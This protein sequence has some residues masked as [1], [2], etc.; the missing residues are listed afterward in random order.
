LCAAHCGQN[1]P[2][3]RFS[4]SAQGGGR[5]V[6]T[7]FCTV[8]S[9]YNGSTQ[10]TDWSVCVLQEPVYDVPIIPPAVGC[11]GD[12]A[13]GQ[14]VVQV[15]FGNSFEGGGWGT[16]RFAQTEVTNT[17]PG[18]I[19]TGPNASSACPGDSGGPLL[20]KYAD[21]TWRTIGIAST[22]QGECGSPGAINAYAAVRDAIPW[23]EEVTGIDVTPCHDADGRWNPTE[24]CTGF[25]T[26]DQTGFGSW[27]DW[28]AGTPSS[29]PS[30]TCG[31]DF[32]Q[33]P[34]STPPI[35]SITA[36]ANNQEF[37]SDPDAGTAAITIMAEGS[38]DDGDAWGVQRAELLID[39]ELIPGGTQTNT[40]YQW[41]AGF[42]AGSYELQ[43]RAYDYWENEALSQ[44]VT[45]Y[46]DQ[47]A[48]ETGGGEE[49][50]SEAG[51]DG[52]SDGEGEVGT[53][54]S[55]DPGSN[56]GDSGG[57]RIDR[58]GETRPAG[59]LALLALLGLRRR[60]RR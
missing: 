11:E 2:S 59:A 15:G 39:G 13:I 23:V 55:G 43:V 9:G 5:T 33:E 52:G 56:S 1:A 16:K 53:G 51:S 19:F 14:T 21:D 7:Q 35:I 32:N 36:P 41:T 40:P 45:V 54:E 28:C 60:R 4:E 8:Y 27:N 46:I 26:G 34:E 50:G 49:S 17:M 47:D 12:V 31:P 38:D 44:L 24:A 18:R 42:P 25:W 30:T 20:V 37:S 29:G 22:L 3:I 48:P 6:P 57:C 58:R 10:A